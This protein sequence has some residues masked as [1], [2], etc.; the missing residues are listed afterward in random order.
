MTTSENDRFERLLVD[1]QSADLFVR[2]QAIEALGKASDPRAVEPL[3]ALLADPEWWV[4][5]A[6]VKALGALGA[7]G[8]PRAADPIAA[9]TY[10][11]D[12]RTTWRAIDTG[13]PVARSLRQLGEP[14]FQALQRVLRDH[15]NE[16]FMGRAAVQAL[17][18]FHDRRAIDALD[19]ALNSPIYEISEAAMV[20]L[21]RFGEEAIPLFVAAL[22]SPVS[23]TR[24]H[25]RMGLRDFGAAAL[26]L[27]LSVLRD[28]PQTHARVEAVWALAALEGDSVDEALE[29]ALD[30][31]DVAVRNAAVEVLGTYGDPNT[32]DRLLDLPPPSGEAMDRIIEPLVESF[33]DFGLTLIRLLLAAL[34]D[35]SRPAIARVRAAR[36]LGELKAKDA[37]EP[38]LAAVNQGDERV[39]AAA[40]EALGNVHDER[41]IAPLMKLLESESKTLRLATIHALASFDTPDVFDALVGIATD[42]GEADRIRFSARFSLLFL[43]QQRALPVL[44]ELALGDDAIL[45]SVALSA[46]SMLDPFRHSADISAFQISVLLELAR[47]SDWKQRGSSLNGLSRSIERDRDPQ[48]LACLQNM[49]DDPEPI[50]RYHVAEILGRIGDRRA[51]DVLA[52]MLQSH[53]LPGSKEQA[54]LVLAKQDDPRALPALEES[55]EQVQAAL[56]AA[57]AA[58]DSDSEKQRQRIMRLYERRDELVT[59]ILRL[60]APAPDQPSKMEKQP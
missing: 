43:L 9:V 13:Y 26:P 29:A 57:L 2:L 30:D 4:C 58:H 6:A 12:I 25:A 44:R 17:D 10:R 24:F 39:R 11:D 28:A 1:A 54:A 53:D 59:A 7:L 20:A 56:E 14:G 3:I 19:L 31:P 45:A 55:A 32:I 27:L 18:E 35:S 37:V 41:A 46:L 21:S 5:I 8:D 51:L 34:K 38:L 15:T 52:E 49:L 48:A 40:A 33:E 50:L 47:S 42:P 22:A 36:V 23:D 16:E 60:R